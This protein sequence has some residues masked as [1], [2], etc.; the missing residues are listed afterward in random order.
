MVFRV[1][2]RTLSALASRVLKMFIRLRQAIRP[3]FHA[4]SEGESE[5]GVMAGLTRIYRLRDERPPKA[6]VPARRDT[7]R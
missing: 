5:P 6:L 4:V 7:R 3:W 1:P 2:G